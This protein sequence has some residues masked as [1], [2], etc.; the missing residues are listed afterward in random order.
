MRASGSL[1]DGPFVDQPSGSDSYVTRI[2]KHNESDLRAF[3]ATGMDYKIFIFPRFFLSLV[4]G[5][6]IVLR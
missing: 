2:S 4:L 3:E 1:R 6:D 5:R